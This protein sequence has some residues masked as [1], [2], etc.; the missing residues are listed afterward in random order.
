MHLELQH[1]SRISFSNM[2]DEL[3]GIDIGGTGIKVAHNDGSTWRLGASDR[4]LKPSRATLT[5]ALRNALA[6]MGFTR[7]NSL[8][9]GLCVPGIASHNG[10]MI[11]LAVNVPGLVGWPFRDLLTSAIGT[12]PDFFVRSTDAQ[13]AMLDWS[14]GRKMRG[15][16]LALVIGTGVGLWVLDDGRPLRVTDNSPG[17]IG[18]IDVGESHAPIGFDGGRGS[19]EAYVGAQ[20]I[21]NSGGISAA[22]APKEPATLAL[23]R[24]I[25]ICHAIYRPDTVLLLG[26]IGIR[27]ANH[28]AFE[29]E[30]RRDLTTLAKP[31][32][33]IIYGDDDHHA[34]R[35]AARLASAETGAQ[36]D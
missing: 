34:A 19:L 2:A 8:R 36:A 24:A 22:F 33:K 31:G 14:Y 20:A 9:V 5:E 10:S 6:D 7:T 25:R 30:V 11:E 13:A 17:H 16:T 4:Y 15:R 23:A 29:E 3:I 28:R 21:K 27:L 18:Q 35:G 32:W 12:E 1:P 26:G